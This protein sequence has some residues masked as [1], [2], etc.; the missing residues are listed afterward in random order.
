MKL[1]IITLA[2]FALRATPTCAQ[3]TFK[4]NDAYFELLG[5]G[6]IGSFNYE[7]Q[8]ADKPG[9]GIRVG[10]GFYPT[11]NG[12]LSIPVGLNYLI[13]LKN[14]RSF[15]EAGLGL[16][17]T[18]EPVTFLDFSGD[19]YNDG[20]YGNFIPSI[21]YRMHTAKSLMLRFAITPIFNK[22]SLTL[23]SIGFSIGKR[24]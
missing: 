22:H 18:S 6:I 9:L 13:N 10:L 19:V 16:T 7:R 23:P 2:L 20:P 17:M 5:N 3:S 21:G 4:Q 11:E 15:I 8:L 1:L 14:Q 12:M 24:F